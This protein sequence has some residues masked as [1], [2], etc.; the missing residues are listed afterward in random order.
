MSF[1][2]G[3]FGP[4]KKR[5]LSTFAKEATLKIFGIGNCDTM[6]LAGRAAH[7]FIGRPKSGV[8]EVPRP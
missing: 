7:E 5:F 4:R 3:D 2:S 8:A 6:T 1:P